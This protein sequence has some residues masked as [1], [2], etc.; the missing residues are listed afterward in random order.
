[1]SWSEASRIGAATSVA[2]LLLV[3]AAGCS[4]QNAG[5]P[6]AGPGPDATK[7]PGMVMEE[8]SAPGEPDERND[9][10]P[11][12]EAPTPNEDPGVFEEESPPVRASKEPARRGRPAPDARSGPLRFTQVWV[13]GQNG[14]FSVR[15]NITNE[16]SRYLNRVEFDWRIVHKN[17]GSELDRGHASAPMLA[18]G[19]TA[20]TSFRGSRDY[21]DAPVRVE[22]EYT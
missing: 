19:E 16:S 8:P 7:A 9:D 17:T 21:I 18:P 5:S 15:A 2:A 1:M 4:S 11:A 10:E 22:F 13:Q 14:M 6:E 20:T 3:A 12:D